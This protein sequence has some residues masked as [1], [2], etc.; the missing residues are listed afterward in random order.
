MNKPLVAASLAGALA[1]V[2]LATPAS[3]GTGVAIRNI[4][5][6]GAA[7]AAALG[8]TN[9]NHK[10]RLK[11]EQETETGRRQASFKAYYY[12]KNGAY[13]TPEQ[14]HEWYVKTYGTEP[15]T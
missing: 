10:K 15:A 4:V 14:I 6:L 7:A 1:L 13:P 5:L 8:I 3:A 12:R 11:D 9:Y 2:P